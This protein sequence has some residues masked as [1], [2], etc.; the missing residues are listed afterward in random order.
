VRSLARVLIALLIPAYWI[1][2][3]APGTGYYHD[4][5]VYLAT[6]KAMATGKGYRILSL[7]S[8]LAQ[9]KYPALYPTLLSAVWRLAPEFPGNV[10]WLKALSLVFTVLWAWTVLTFIREFTTFGQQAW[11]LVLFVLLSPWVIFLSGITMADT[12][13]AFLSMYCIL[14]LS[15]VVEQKVR[16]PMQTVVFAA[17][18]ASG[19][20]QARTAGVALIGA[21]AV[22]LML[23]RMPRRAAVFALLCGL[24]CIPWLLW[25]AGHPAPMDWVQSY[26]TKADYRAG[27]N[28]FEGFTLPQALRIAGL[29][30]MYVYLSLWLVAGLPIS[31]LM[32]AISLPLWI[33]VLVGAVGG[34]RTG[35]LPM[36]LWVLFYTAMLVCYVYTPSRY[37]ACIFPILLVFGYQGVRLTLGKG[38]EVREVRMAAGLLVAVSLVWLF[39]Q[40][41]VNSWWTIQTGTA[42]V[43]RAA[44]DDWGPTKEMM[45]W[46]KENTPQDAVIAADSDP[47]IYLYTG[48]KA[49][50]FFRRQYSSYYFDDEASIAMGLDGLEKHLR[51]NKVDYIAMT[52]MR[53][54][55]ESDYFH[56]LLSTEIRENERAFQLVHTGTEPGYLIYAVNRR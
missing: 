12:L 4:D 16:N 35:W 41:S 19:A 18:L 50:H 56:R 39:W 17:M 32:F 27:A 47:A 44:R 24:F 36:R 11:W 6:A 7:P 54:S 30:A 5:G 55:V 28:L 23:R 49:I 37:M 53:M 20:F 46:I 38:L 21:A 48:R 25:Q 51:Q 2:V 45:G 9:T 1:S 13:F 52:P 8:E 40:V 31:P 34:G 14:L 42:S 10:I 22:V 3:S 43:G 15:R 33:F 26:Y 29:N